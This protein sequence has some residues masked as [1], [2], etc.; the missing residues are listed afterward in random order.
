MTDGRDAYVDAVLDGV[1]AKHAFVREHADRVVKALSDDALAVVVVAARSNATER[2]VDQAIDRRQIWRKQLV[3]AVVMLEEADDLAEDLVESRVRAVE[4]NLLSG[5]GRS[6]PMGV[7]TRKV[8]EERRAV[9]ATERADARRIKIADPD[10]PQLRVGGRLPSRERMRQMS[11]AQLNLTLR[12]FGVEISRDA[13]LA[14]EVRR[15]SQ[16]LVR[17]RRPDTALVERVH[18]NAE[19]AVRRSLQIQVKDVIRRYTFARYKAAGHEEF[20]WVCVLDNHSCES[21]LARH[22]YDPMP[23]DEWEQIGEPGSHNLL[24]NGQCRCEL[25]PAAFF[26]M[27]T[28]EGIRAAVA[29]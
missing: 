27:T 10:A 8:L 12:R 1:D 29:A 20:K 13:S 25:E 26:L 17:T 16:R 2:D 28:Q 19:A 5:R 15:A 21:C 24:C 14:S 6:K 22:Y 23:M 4:R 18:R 11:D 3:A 7:V 9:R